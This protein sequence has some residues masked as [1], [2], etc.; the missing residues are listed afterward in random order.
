MGRHHPRLTDASAGC[1]TECIVNVL[2]VDDQSSAR[3]LLRHVVEGIDSDIVVSDFGDPLEALAWSRDTDPDLVLLDYRMPGMDGLEFAREFRQVASHR[4]IPVVVISA[5]GDEPVRQAA[6]EVGVMDFLSKPVRPLEL[7]ARCRNL[8]D[9]RQQR[10]TLKERTRDLEEQVRVGLAEIEQREREMLFRMARLVEY[11]DQGTGKHLLRMARY[12]EMVAEDLGLSDEEVG[13]IAAAAPMHDIG[14]IGIPDSILLKPGKLTDEEMTIMKTHPQIGYDVLSNS[15]SRFI[16]M[17]AVISLGHHERW[18]GSG[19]PNG[20]K[21]EE[22]PLPARIV[23]LADVFDALLSE[24]SYKRAWTYDEVADYL[25]EHS[26]T[27]FDPVCVK[28]I[29]S[30]PERVREIQNANLVPSTWGM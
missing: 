27:L 28:A 18:D 9:L 13:I 24:R 4:D 1:Q 23:A 11:R 10:V 30:H 2:I 19:Y 21:G 17:S 7:R 15:Q 22:I 3:T 26:G 14:K 29:L 16:Q 8:L 12:A 20:L 6:L 25:N 5:F